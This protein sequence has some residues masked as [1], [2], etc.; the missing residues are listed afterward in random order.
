MSTSAQP[1]QQVSSPADTYALS[2]TTERGTS[3]P[4]IPIIPPPDVYDTRH[5]L[6][7]PAILAGEDKRRQEVDGDKS[8]D[9]DVPFVTPVPK[10]KCYTCSFAVSKLQ[11]CSLMDSGASDHC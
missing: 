3:N 9:I 7:H 8:G 11:T 10:T 4:F 6:I 1:A 2:A 5:D